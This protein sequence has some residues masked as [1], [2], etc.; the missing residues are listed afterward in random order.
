[1]MALQVLHNLP[2]TVG[3]KGL[4]RILSGSVESPIGPDRC[5]EWGKL[6]TWTKTATERLIDGL[7]EQG[8]LR[9]N[10]AGQYP[11]LELT[12]AGYDVLQGRR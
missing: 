7:L 11:C 1:M 6:E 5:P 8:L 3:R 9:R 4:L 12:R 10:D 2:F